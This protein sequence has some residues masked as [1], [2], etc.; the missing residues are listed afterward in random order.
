MHELKLKTNPRKD[1]DSKPDYIVTLDMF[2]QIKTVGAAW[3]KYDE[4]T[5]EKEITIVL[6]KI[7]KYKTGYQV[8]EYKV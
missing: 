3:E 2:P 8:I 7:G 1:T 6:N 5:G 4:N